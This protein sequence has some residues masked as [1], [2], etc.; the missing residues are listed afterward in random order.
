VLSP[1]AASSVR[2]GFQT[3][4]VRQA[5]QGTFLFKLFMGALTGISLLVGGVGIMNVLLA[6]VIERTKEIGIRKA[7]GARQRDILLQFLS[8]R[9][10]SRA[11]AASLA[12]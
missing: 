1:V 12:R 3:L 2:V 9:S 7:A 11:L 6:S 4:R 5:R 10:R 8:D